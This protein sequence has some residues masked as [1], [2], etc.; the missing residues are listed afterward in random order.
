[1]HL[2]ALR[3][4]PGDLRDHVTLCEHATTWQ[5]TRDELNAQNALMLRDEL[6][7]SHRIMLWA[8]HSHVS[9][10]FS[11]GRIPTMGQHI[12]E[13]IDRSVYTIGLFAGGGRFIDVA[14]LSVHRLPALNKVGVERI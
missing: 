2:A 14:P 6:S 13:R 11:R 1:M 7:T 8:H 3:L 10:N 4:I 12:R 5:E 9:Y